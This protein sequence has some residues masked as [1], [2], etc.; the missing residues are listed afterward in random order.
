MTSALQSK[1]RLT[2]AELEASRAEN[3]YHRSLPVVTQH[4]AERLEVELEDT[5]H[6]LDDAEE[7]LAAAEKQLDDVEERMEELE[8]ENARVCGEAVFS[9]TATPDVG[10]A[11]VAFPSVQIGGS[12]VPAVLFEV[13]QDLKTQLE[14][15]K[16]SEQVLQNQ[17]NQY[18]EALSLCRDVIEEYQREEKARKQSVQVFPIANH[19]LQ[20][21]LEDAKDKVGHYASRVEC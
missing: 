11:K 3:A 8:E 20:V 19:S 1:L 9:S 13:V 2:E 5:R 14:D 18:H 6:A 10:D 16:T 15:A 21:E 12:T 17:V 7:R 4:R